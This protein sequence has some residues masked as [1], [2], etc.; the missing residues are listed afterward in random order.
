MNKIGNILFGFSLFVLV[1]AYSVNENIFRLGDGAA[2]DKEIIFN[3]GSANPPGLRWNETDSKIQFS[4]DGTNYANLGSGSGSGAGVNLATENGD[5][6]SGTNN[7]TNT[8]ATFTV[9]TTAANV[10]YG[11]ASGSWDASAGS[12]LLTYDDVAVPN[13]MEGMLCH[14][15]FV[16]KGGDANIAARV[17][18][19]SDVVLATQTLSAETSFKT[20]SKIPFVCPTDGTVAFELASSAD[21][22]IIYIDSVFFGLS[23][24]QAGAVVSAWES[25]TPS[26]TG[27]S[28][29]TWNIAQY[30]RIG[31]SMEI[32]MQ[33]SGVTSSAQVELT[34][35]GSYTAASNEIRG[36]F[37]IDDT[38]GSFNMYRTSGGDISFYGASAAVGSGTYPLSSDT[39]SIWGII[40]ISEWSNSGTVNLIND[41][42]VYA[43]AR[44]RVEGITTTA[45]GTGVVDLDYKTEAFTSG[46]TYDGTDEF[47]INADGKYFI[48]AYL[49]LTTAAGTDVELIAYKNTSTAVLVSKGQ[50]GG[51]TYM[52]SGIL[53]LSDGDTLKIS[54]NSTGSLTA[55]DAAI[56][57]Y[58]E[59]TKLAEYS[60]GDAVGFGLAD[61]NNAGLLTRY[62]TENKA[63]D[64]E[65]NSGNFSFTRIGNVV[66]ISGDT[67]IGCTASTVDPETSDGFVPANY[68]PSTTET[69]N[70]YGVNAGP[71]SFSI[72]ITTSGRIIIEARNTSTGST[73]AITNAGYPPVISYIV[74]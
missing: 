65:F 43:N 24:Q 59:I 56:K 40:P 29:A 38:L 57:T 11:D 44:A 36:T 26:L 61:A 51:F 8:G 39:V 73:L 27:I 16:Y 37:Y 15:S 1:A 20:V 60:A 68:R 3:E 67:A 64:N 49:N 63:A 71:N 10:A 55:N 19:G 18:D 17:I 41:S 14:F 25:F 32:N 23:S 5:F 31:D 33:G 42:V 70:L 21:A 54:K 7:W 53:D 28:A 47:T 22:A 50:S 66:T 2:S 74:D 48:N 35:P 62:E 58:I 52:L 46:I 34:I 13:G 30:R 72:R 69:R 45:L 9:T 12:Q 4:N 6:E